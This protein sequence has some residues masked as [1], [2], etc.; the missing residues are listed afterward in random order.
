[1]LTFF[2]PIK[3]LVILL[4]HVI[5]RL[6]IGFPK[7]CSRMNNEEIFSNGD[8][9]QSWCYSGGSDRIALFRSHPDVISVRS[10]A[11]M[12]KMML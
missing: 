9:A 6:F 8:A 10:V 12:N 2:D 1:M 4:Q 5:K 3:L 11:M 7:F